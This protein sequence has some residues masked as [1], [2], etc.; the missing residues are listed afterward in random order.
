MTDED[1]IIFLLR[2]SLF[3]ILVSNRDWGIVLK[4]LVHLSYDSEKVGMP[5]I[6]FL[7]VITDV[8][9]CLWINLIVHDMMHNMNCWSLRRESIWNTHFYEERSSRTRENKW[10]TKIF[11]VLGA[12]DNG[13]VLVVAIEL[14]YLILTHLLMR[15]HRRVHCTL[16]GV[17]LLHCVLL[18][19]D[20]RIRSHSHRKHLRWLLAIELWVHHLWLHHHLLV[21][22]WSA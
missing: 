13:N 12:C 16:L 1:F 2:L 14:C 7:Q 22:P 19:R 18:L 6:P 5:T 10:N 3:Q 17:M 4:L 20:L 21:L 11:F 9:E 8:H 15:T